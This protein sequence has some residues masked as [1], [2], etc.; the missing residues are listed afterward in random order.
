MSRDMAKGF[1]ADICANPGDDAPRLIFADYL[2]DHGDAGRAEF[3]RVQVARARLPEWDAAQVGLRLREAELLRLHGD[4]WRAELPVPPWGGVEWGGFRRGF[5]AEVKFADF[6]RLRECAAGCWAAA[7]VESAAV[8]WPRAADGCETLPPIPALRELRVSGAILSN[9]DAEALAAAPLLSTLHTLD[10]SERGFDLEAFRA[11]ATSPHLAGLRTLRAPVDGI[12]GGIVRVLREGVPFT[13]LEDLDLTQQDDY[14]AY[15]NDASIDEPGIEALAAWP[16][17]AGL[18]S[19]TLTGNGIGAPG[20]EMLLRSP[21]VVGL[22]TLRLRRIGLHGDGA[23]AFHVARPALRLEALDM[24]ENLVEHLGM[25]GAADIAGAACLS[26]LKSLRLDRCELGPE[27]AALLASASFL[28][29]LRVLD[30][31]HNKI[32]PQG[33]QAILGSRP[34]MLHTLG[35]EG[36][37]LGDPGVSWLASAPTADGL[38]DVNLAY[39]RLRDGGAEALAASGHLRS[40]LALRLLDNPIGKEAGEAVRAS[41]L[42]QR[43]MLLEMSDPPIPWVAGDDDIPF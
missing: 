34:P 10:L 11:L 42:G 23:R 29:S 28:S 37:D 41:P 1:L 39:N 25:K 2:E 32:G 21:L 22:K 27:S 33:L 12:G 40:L 24:G 7:P 17:L 13:A 35:L 20:L 18:R 14:D 4:G 43:L 36:N 8:R 19:L 26:E 3:I 15:V 5:V 31:G 6:R 9:L 38:L 16:G 30:L